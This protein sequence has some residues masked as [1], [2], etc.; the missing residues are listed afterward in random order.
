MRARL[1]PLSTHMATRLRACRSQT[2]PKPLTDVFRKLV[3][4]PLV[5]LH[6]AEVEVPSKVRRGDTSICYVDQRCDIS[7]LMNVFRNRLL[8]IQYKP[9]DNGPSAPFI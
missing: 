3:I 1:D 7:D 4:A 9:N 6:F 5:E 8:D 2:V